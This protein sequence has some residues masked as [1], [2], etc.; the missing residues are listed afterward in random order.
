MGAPVAERGAAG[1]GVL[2]YFHIL[3]SNGNLLSI[4]NKYLD[5][6]QLF[7]FA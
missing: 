3:K 4:S 1:K 6:F 5:C 2:S 7:G